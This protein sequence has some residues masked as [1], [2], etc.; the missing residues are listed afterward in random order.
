MHGLHARIVAGHSLLLRALSV[1]AEECVARLAQTDGGDDQGAGAASVS[2]G[3]AAED[4]D[5]SADEPESENYIICQFDKVR[6]V[7]VSLW[8][9]ST[10]V[11]H[12]AVLTCLSLSSIEAC[13]FPQARSQLYAA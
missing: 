12:S 13:L 6:A 3:G 2:T 4:S 9:R 11:M 7:C 10:C 8:S 1:D 5:G